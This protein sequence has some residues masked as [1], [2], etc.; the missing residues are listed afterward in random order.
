MTILKKIADEIDGDVRDDLF[1]KSIYSV[2]AS[3]YEIT[4]LGVVL[5]KTTADIIKTVQIAKGE[6]VALIARGGG[7]GI[8]GGCLGKGI[9]I[10]TSRYMTKIEEIGHDFAWVEPGVIQDDLNHALKSKLLRL[11]PDTSTANRATLGGML[12]ANAAG[13][14][15]LRYGSMKDHVLEVQLILSSGDLITVGQKNPPWLEEKIREI[16]SRYQDAIEK[17]FPKIKRRASGY[18]LDALL[19][20][21]LNL[22]KLIAG[23]EGSLGVISKIKMGLSPLLKSTKLAL[24]TFDNLLQCFKDLPELLKL[25]PASIELIDENVLAM[26]KASPIFKNKLNFLQDAKALLLLEFEESAPIGKICSEE[27]K[28]TLFE[29]RKLGLGLLLSKRSYKRAI[30]FIEDIAIPPDHLYDFM[31]QFQILL[32]QKGLQAGIYGHAG[33]GCLHIR[34]YIDL[35]KQEEH[36]LLFEL[37]QDVLSLVVKY[38]GVMSGEHGD[39]IIR[40]HLNKKLFG[41]ELFEAFSEIK[42]LFDPDN[43]MNPG[44]IVGHINPKEDLRLSPATKQVQLTTFLNFEKEGGLQLAADLCNGNGQCRKK[45]GLMCPSYQGLSDERLTTRARAQSLRAILNGKMPLKELS[46]QG[47]HDVLDLCLECKGCKVE[48]PS[49]INMA[50]MKAEVL[51][52]YNNKHGVNLRTKLF[53]HISEAFE[54]GS[55]FPT[56]FNLIS[57]NPLLKTLLKIDSK[58]ALPKLAK[59]RFS[60]LVKG[61]KNGKKVILFNDTYTEFIQPE[62]GLSTVDLLNSLGFEVIIPPYQCCGKPLIS[63]GFLKQAKQKALSL[64]EGLSP[65]GN[66]PIIA[67]EPSCLFTL[68]DDFADLTGSAHHLEVT[69]LDHFLLE[70]NI[71]LT[72]KEDILIHTHCHQK[73]SHLSKTTYDLLKNQGFTVEE[74]DSG[75]CGM[76]GSFGYEK[77]HSELSFKIAKD[78]LFPAISGSKATVLA[79]GFSC[80]CQIDQGIKKKSFHLAQ[81]LRPY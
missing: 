58:R 59:K 36:D 5:P 75:C 25:N 67:L 53:G 54:K 48:C 78:R 52:H 32:K 15:F 74:V 64:I 71:S 28:Q 70:Q 20:N 8:A 17:K 34:P 21:P 38:Q 3:I 35:R 51:Y 80:R 6:G 10:D 37:Q 65:Y 62:I 61:N 14:H 41:K 33:D 9:I 23:S 24:L 19:E 63:K 68:K 18:N 42:Y 39:G 60:E 69:S 46:G 55:Q 49:S 81:I 26:G 2:D 7:T 66:L 50:K 30:A 27:E 76:A 72:P 56:L 11:G 1:S 57:Q 77:E 44:K 31:G 16:A 12:A 40:S 4:P 45:T 79:N 43:L 29:M 73:A 22:A 47:L 13:K